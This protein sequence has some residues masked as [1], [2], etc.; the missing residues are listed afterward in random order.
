VNVWVRTTTLAAI[1]AVMVGASS[2]PPKAESRLAGIKL[3][4]T[5]V[6]LAKRF[7]SPTDI[8]PVFWND[9]GGGGTP[10][11]GPAAGGGGPSPV[12]GGGGGGPMPVGGGGGGR[13]NSAGAPI[14]FIVPPLSLKQM[15]GGG[16]GMAE[17]QIGGGG[18]IGG[19]SDMGGGMGGGGGSTGQGVQYVRWIYQRGAG[20]SINVVLN[21]FNRVVQIEALGVANSAVRTSR[22]ITLGSS[23]ASVIKAYQN[24]DAYE[25]GGDYIMMRFLRT[26]K[27]AFRFTRENARGAFK[28]T[29]IV[30]SAGKA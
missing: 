8:F 4:D 24:P 7:G 23:L 22:G 30:V 11:G 29:G 1:A 3:Y 5:G 28:V 19:G 25:I 20:G 27:V 14:D 13:A 9:Q 12:G 2:A 17:P 18:G 10:G 16:G 26:A 15:K 21:K 6:D